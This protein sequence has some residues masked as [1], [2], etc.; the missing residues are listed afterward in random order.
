MTE[1]L[2]KLIGGIISAILGGFFL[3]MGAIWAIKL[4]M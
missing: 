2:I 1:F 3:A 4:F